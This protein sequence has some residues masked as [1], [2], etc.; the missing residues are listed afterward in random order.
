MLVAMLGLT[1]CTPVVLGTK[2]ATK[3]VTAPVKVLF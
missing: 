3:V 2:A 1:A